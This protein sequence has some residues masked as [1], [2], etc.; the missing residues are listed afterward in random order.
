MTATLAQCIRVTTAAV[1]LTV[2]TVLDLAEG[3]A[4]RLDPPPFDGYAGFD[5]LDGYLMPQ[6]REREGL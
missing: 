1:W 2:A 3:V 5:A 6:P 4:D